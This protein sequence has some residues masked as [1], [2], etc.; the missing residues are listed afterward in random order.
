[1]T[2]VS[3]LGGTYSNDQNGRFSAISTMYTLGFSDFVDDFHMICKQR[4][5]KTGMAKVEI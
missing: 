1:M 4:V 5:K 2:P 3:V